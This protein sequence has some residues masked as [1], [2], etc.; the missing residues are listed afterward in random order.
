MVEELRAFKSQ[1][2]HLISVCWPLRSASEHLVEMQSS[3]KAYL[4][5]NDLNERDASNEVKAED[6]GHDG[7]A[8]AQTY[9]LQPSTRRTWS[10]KTPLRRVHIAL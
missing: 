10:K 5:T 4:P 7:A 6:R 3:S 2:W 1:T 8:A 9:A